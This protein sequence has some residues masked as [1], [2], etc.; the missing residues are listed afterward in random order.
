MTDR[1]P[2]PDRCPP[3]RPNCGDAASNH[4]PGKTTMLIPSRAFRLYRAPL[5]ICAFVDVYPHGNRFFVEVRNARGSGY[6]LA[7]TL[8]ASSAPVYADHEAA[9]IAARAWCRE[10]GV[11]VTV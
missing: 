5:P 4:R 6:L 3:M 1:P 2:R 9:A 8:I 7:E 11:T 10:N